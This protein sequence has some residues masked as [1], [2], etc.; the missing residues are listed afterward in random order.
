MAGAARKLAVRLPGVPRL[1]AGAASAAS[2]SELIASRR[3]VL[4]GVGRDNNR[5]GQLV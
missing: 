4:G 3:I 5:F 1:L 2:D